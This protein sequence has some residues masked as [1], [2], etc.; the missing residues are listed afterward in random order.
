MSI[1][2]SRRYLR[3]R[4]DVAQLLFT[5]RGILST[6]SSVFDPL[7][8]ISPVILKGK[9]ILQEVC[10][11]QYDWDTQLPDDIVTRWQKWCCDL[12]SLKQLEIKRCVKPNNF[13]YSKGSPENTGGS[14]IGI[15]QLLR[16]ICHN[17]CRGL[18]QCSVYNR[19]WWNILGL[20]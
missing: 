5:R 13:A 6:V 20:F 11:A 17:L 1:L 9:Q 10:R 7:G 3:R 14:G 4:S 16:Q 15:L 2:R 8:F 19:T 18:F 12:R